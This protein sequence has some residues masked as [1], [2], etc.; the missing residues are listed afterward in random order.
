MVT[1]FWPSFHQFS[2]FASESGEDLM[3]MSGLVPFSDQ[4]D[5]ITL[6]F[7][8]LQ[9]ALDYFLVYKV[10]LLQAKSVKSL[11]LHLIMKN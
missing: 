6:K 1:S 5:Q 10:Q 9:E 8:F 4:M 11:F 7:I 3:R 2:H